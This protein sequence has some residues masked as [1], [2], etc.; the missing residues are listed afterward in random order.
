MHGD[1]FKLE[2]YFQEERFRELFKV[3]CAI[4][5][6][7]VLQTETAAEKGSATELAILKL[8]KKAGFSYQKIRDEHE[9]PQRYPFNSERKRM[10]T[11][12]ELGGKKIILLKGAS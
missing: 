9:N 2:E 4:N 3:S 6:T 7:A 5:G 1:S 10:S 8:L 12:I 11:I